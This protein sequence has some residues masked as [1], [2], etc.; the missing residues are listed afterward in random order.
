MQQTTV[1]RETS[2]HSATREF[3]LADV[4]LIFRKRRALLLTFA[5]G[6]MVAATLGGLVRGNRYTAGGELQIRPGSAADLKQSLSSVLSSNGLDD[7]DITI[8]SD[9]RIIESDSILL[10]VVRQLHLQ[11]KPEFLGGLVKTKTSMVGG[12]EV[13][14]LHGDLNDPFVRDTILKI[15]RKH[16]S[17][18]RVPRTQM[19]SLRYE[20]RSAPLSTSIVNE[21]IHEFIENNYT[22]RYQS[23]SQVVKWLNAQMDDLRNQVQT[24]QD[25][26]VDLQKKLGIFSLD[27]SSDLLLAQV[28][29]LERGYSKATEER[30]AAEARY[31][32]LSTM[33]SEHIVDSATALGTDYPVSVLATLR[34]QREQVANSL[35][36]LRPVYGPNYPTVKQDVEQ[37][38]AIDAQIKQQEDRVLNQAKDALVLAESAEKTAKGLLDDKTSGIYAMRDD[39]VKY[40]LV[41]QESESNRN[42]Y[43][44]ILR[45][46]R[47]ATVD[48]GL[49]AAD[50]DIID[51]A[52][53]PSEPSNLPPV[54]LALIGLFF[55][56]FIGTG[57][58]LFMEKLDTKI[59]DAREV[60]A[61]L[62]IPTLAIIPV[63][64]VSS[65]A[66]Q[67]KVDTTIPEILRLPNSTFSESIRSLRTAM[68]LSGTSRASRVIGITSCQPAEGK[69]T[70]STNLACSLAQGGHRVILIEADM[71]LPTLAFRLGLRPARGLSE[72]LSGMNTLSEVIQKSPF[73]DTL[74]VIVG[75]TIPPL[76][77]DLLG[78]ENFNAMLVELRKL[79]DYLI[80]DTPPALSVT[81]SAIVGSK[82]EGIILVIRQD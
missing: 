54:A 36:K 61:V 1:N 13:Q 37:L 14:I 49:D 80:I 66:K 5:I 79:Y 60:E 44:S 81:D 22:S 26:L 82:A 21:I 69:T 20:S 31:R 63:L 29:D 18:E 27:K 74:D 34:G 38:A 4:Q 59:H 45:R 41:S 8:E 15:I 75:G 11:D 17:I 9:T 58:A 78:S 48:A 47:E 68:M 46:L 57:I 56:L 2:P 52:S 33:P 39:V 62:G 3:T 72:C 64:K 43:E 76:P 70:T 6:A 77:S 35:A 24:S 16:L 42:M 30:V 19:M 71:R 10:S 50:I 40:E 23:A 73:L 51:L 55:G 67:V 12:R 25:R 53:I 7:L 32:I 28:G 65:S